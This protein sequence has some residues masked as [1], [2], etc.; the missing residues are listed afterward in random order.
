MALQTES[1]KPTQA[2]VQAAFKETFTLQDAS[3]EQAQ[4]YLDEINA[5]VLEVSRNQEWMEP[6]ELKAPPFNILAML[7]WWKEDMIARWQ[8][9]FFFFMCIMYNLYIN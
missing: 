6:V 8:L 1:Q 3:L 7:R 2:G 5:E 4:S 9:I